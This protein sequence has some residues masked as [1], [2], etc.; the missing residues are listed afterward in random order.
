MTKVSSNKTN[1]DFMIFFEQDECSNTISKV[2]GDKYLQV[3]SSS[4]T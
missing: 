3:G 4:S 2:N 1:N